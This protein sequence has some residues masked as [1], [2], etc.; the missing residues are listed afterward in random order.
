MGP[1]GFERH[2]KTSHPQ[3]AWAGGAANAEQIAADK[4]TRLNI[5]TSFEN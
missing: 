1:A 5:G 4:K 3:L 2:S